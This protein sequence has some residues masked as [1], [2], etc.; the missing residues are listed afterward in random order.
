MPNVSFKYI[1][2]PSI[3]GICAVKN[4]VGDYELVTGVTCDFVVSSIFRKQ[5]PFFIANSLMLVFVVITFFASFFFFCLSKD[6]HEL[7]HSMRNTHL[8]TEVKQQ[9]ATFALEYVAV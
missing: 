2:G 3:A 1:T 6:F 5:L 4:D 7:W 8:I 9:W